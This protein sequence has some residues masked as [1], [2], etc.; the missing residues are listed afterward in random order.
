MMLRAA[1]SH[2]FKPVI[3][4]GRG[5]FCFLELLLVNFLISPLKF[6]FTKVGAS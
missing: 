3:V 1:S 4:V 5:Y 6:S 2:F